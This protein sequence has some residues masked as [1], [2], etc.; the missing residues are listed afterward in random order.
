MKT[1][2][3]CWIA[4]AGA[5]FSQALAGEPKLTESLPKP[6]ANGAFGFAAATAEGWKSQAMARASQN[7]GS[8]QTQAV[9]L[10]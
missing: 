1:Y 9:P 10:W 2:L 8:S 4:V 5:L 7:D 3:E 6:L